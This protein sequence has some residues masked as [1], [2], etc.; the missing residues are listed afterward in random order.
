MHLL[1]AGV[2][3]LELSSWGFLYLCFGRGKKIDGCRGQGERGAAAEFL[4]R[5]KIDFCVLVISPAPWCSDGMVCS[6]GGQAAQ[7]VCMKGA[8]MLRRL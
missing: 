2:D 8:V 6:H 3:K 4:R 5:T 7:M 1:T